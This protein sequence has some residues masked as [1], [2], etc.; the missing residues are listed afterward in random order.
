M[1]RSLIARLGWATLLAGA[2]AL[3]AACIGG[4]GGDSGSAQL[5][6]LNL[7]TNLASVDVSL[8]GAKTFSA[9]TTNTLT[10]STSVTAQAYTMSV[11]QTGDATTLFSSPFSLSKDQH[12]TGLVWGASDGLRFSLLPEDENDSLSSG[13]TAVRVFNA[14]INSGAFD[15]YLTPATQN[16]P[17]LSVVAPTRSNVQPASTSSS[18]LSGYAVV[19]TGSYRLRITAAGNP[20][21]VR[22]DVPSVTLSDVQYATVI[23]TAGTG[24]ALVNATILIQQGTVLTSFNNGQSRI[25]VVAGVQ[26]NSDNTRSSISV[27][28]DGSA[29]ASGTQASPA[30]GPY[31]EITAGN[32]DIAVSLNGSVVSTTTQAFTAGGDYTLMAYGPQASPQVV[33]L[34]DDNSV[35]VTGKVS[36]RVV[37][38]DDTAGPISLLVDNGNVYVPDILPGTASSYVLA[39][40]TT[41]NVQSSLEIDSQNASTFGPIY[42]ND[43][44]TLISQGVYTIFL[45]RGGLS[46]T[47]SQPAPTGI[48]RKDR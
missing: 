44:Q 6:V 7:S 17:D 39:N 9:V 32:H 21:D 16:V 25:R 8:S 48:L 3:L 45:L 38:G 14:T 15:V 26:L 34:A 23:I 19:N 36:L 30:V 4:G 41:N 18:G 28:V 37:N 40:A 46:T 12:Y 20:N 11:S 2:T 47:T 42:R 22:L 13:T 27:A 1:T 10:S 24:N 31:T 35:P 5:R 33:L 43:A 29:L